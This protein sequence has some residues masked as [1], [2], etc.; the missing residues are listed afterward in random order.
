VNIIKIDTLI[1]QLELLKESRREYVLLT[2]H[3]YDE[4]NNKIHSIHSI[5]VEFG[6][7]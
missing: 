1:K 6:E 7:C 3:Q 5:V 4:N 2:G